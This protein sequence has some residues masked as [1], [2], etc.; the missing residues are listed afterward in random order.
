[1]EREYDKLRVFASH[2][3]SLCSQCGAPVG[4]EEVGARVLLSRVGL[5]TMRLFLYSYVCKADGQE[6]VGGVALLTDRR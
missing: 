5:A 3:R 6:R 1:M 2:E 4:R